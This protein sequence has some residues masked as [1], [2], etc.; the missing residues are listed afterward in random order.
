MILPQSDIQ[1]GLQLS[2]DD[3]AIRCTHRDSKRFFIRLEREGDLPPDLVFSDLTFDTSEEQDAISAL[4]QIE[5]AFGGLSRCR[6]VAI[7][8]IYPLAQTENPV[9][10]TQILET[11]AQLVSVFQEVFHK[12]GQP[13]FDDELQS[14]QGRF[15]TVLKRSSGRG[16]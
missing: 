4:L 13:V 15:D 3:F 10:Q 2:S 8:N 1:S 14:F 11:H 6:S 5:A 9:P 12:L 7:R 16:N